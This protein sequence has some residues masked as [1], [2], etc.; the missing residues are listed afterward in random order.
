M[1]PI[2]AFI[3]IV[4]IVQIVLFFLIRSKRKKEKEKSI[5]E[6]YNIQSP[7]DAFKLMN[8]MSVPE[9]DRLEIERLYLGED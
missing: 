2:I 6:K 7:G 9:K 4:L 1:A 3:S 8:D 5:I